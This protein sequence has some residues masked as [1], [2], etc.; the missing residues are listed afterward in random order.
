VSVSL[1]T[2]ALNEQSM[3]AGLLASARDVV[4]EVIIGIDSR[5]TDHTVAVARALNCR[6]F[7]FDWHDSFAEARNL[8][9]DHARGDWILVLDPDERLLPEGRRAICDTLAGTV[10][11]EVDG[12]LTQFIETD[13]D[14]Q[15]QDEPVV[16][17]SRLFRNSP[18]LRYVGRVHEEVRY[19]PDP[20]RTYCAMLEGGPHI[21][22]YGLDATIWD[23][24]RKRERDRRLLHLRL[25]DNPHDAVAHC[26]LALMARREGRPLA[27][28]MFARRALACGPRTLHDDRVAHMEQLCRRET[29]CFTA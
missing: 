9:I 25:R 5:T 23:L 18:D 1:C 2:I 19:L 24:R 21:Q 8:T 11:L 13:L 22:H 28:R 29:S 14:D 16:S 10:P 7:E 17:S 4:D 26:Y 20:P 3:L 27:A 15:P 12:F 6:T